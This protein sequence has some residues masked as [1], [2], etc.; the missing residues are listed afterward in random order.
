MVNGSLTLPTVAP[1]P[2]SNAA[3]TDEIN[4]YPS[5]GLILEE[6]LSSFVF[7]SEY[8]KI[9]HF[10]LSPLRPKSSP[11]TLSTVLESNANGIEIIL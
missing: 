4:Q 9:L 3:L 11:K 6:P 2:V 8:R 5:P 10:D 7:P 1:G